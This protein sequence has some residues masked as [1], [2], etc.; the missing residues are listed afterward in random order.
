MA[1]KKVRILEEIHKTS[2]IGRFIIE[3]EKGI[4][5]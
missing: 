5:S 4:D 3:W 1:D 2:Q